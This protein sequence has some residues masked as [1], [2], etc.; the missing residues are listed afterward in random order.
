MKKLVLLFALLTLSAS[1]F[2]QTRVLFLGNSYTYGNNLPQLFAD[3]S[4]A[5]GHDVV[6]DMR[7]SGGEILAGHVESAETMAKIRQ[8][9]WDYVILQE[10]SQI[11][12]IPFYRDSLMYPAAR[13]LK[14]IIREGNPCASLMFFM[15][16]GRRFGGKQCDSNGEHCSPDFQNFEHMQDSLEASYKRIADELRAE[17]SPVGISWLYALAND[18]NLVLH[19]D[20]NSHPNLAGS[21]LAAC[22]FYAMIWEENPQ[23]SSF[24]AGQSAEQASFLQQAANMTALAVG[25]EKWNK[26][27]DSLEVSFR[28]PSDYF[29]ESLRFE[30]EVKGKGKN[31]TYFWDLGDGNT[32][33]TASFN[34]VYAESGEYLVSLRVR[35]ECGEEKVFSQNV[36]AFALA[37]EEES[38][39]DIQLFPNPSTAT[40]M[41]SGTALQQE[42]VIISITT[43]TG[44]VLH[45]LEGNGMLRQALDVGHLPT[46][47]YLL[48]VET[49]ANVTVRKWVKQ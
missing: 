30:A 34:H 48:K 26:N 8:G 14:N 23:N 1:A 49:P 47:A 15:T 9:N 32:S 25:T 3:L 17:V 27:K 20:D 10:Q 18:P 29:F 33:T 39:T 38:H 13:E 22:T 46:G 43:I 41:L 4:R 36:E 19:T 45:S 44:K 5:G 21:Y 2:A 11:P 16:W 40:L 35:N 37:L 12:T 7:A 28:D 6:V 31:Y 42:K 24:F